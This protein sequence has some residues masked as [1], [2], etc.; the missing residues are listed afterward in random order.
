M[1]ALTDLQAQITNVQGDVTALQADS[2]TVL[3]T[4]QGLQNGT[5]NADDPQVEAAATAMATI[6]SGLQAID[7]SLKGAVPPASG[8][9]S[10]SSAPTS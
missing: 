1:S 8:S 2:A 9:S 4:L 6:H 5:V 10:S 3:A 7:A